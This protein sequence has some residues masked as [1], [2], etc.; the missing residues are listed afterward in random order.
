MTKT[1]CL[2]AALAVAIP[3]MA[4][5]AEAQVAFIPYIGYDFDVGHAPNPGAL[6]V[7]VGVE[8]GF[9]SLPA[10][11]LALRPSA[12][13]YFVNAPPEVTHEFFQLNADAIADIAPLGPGIGLFV[14]GGL[15]VGFR[16]V[17]DVSTTPL[18][19]NLLGGIDVGTGFVSPFIQG[20]VTLMEGTRFGIQGGVKLAL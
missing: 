12:E 15:G 3:L 5:R 7:G 10:V 14:G 1:L 19:V 11:T 17:N 4:P 13:F 18:G 9:I 2:L 20:R 16:T 8:F 6:L